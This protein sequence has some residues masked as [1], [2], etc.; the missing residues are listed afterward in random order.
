MVQV[1]IKFENGEHLEISGWLLSG[2]GL[3]M[4]SYS[5]CYV[6]N[7]P[8]FANNFVQNIQSSLLFNL[9]I[10]DVGSELEI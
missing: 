8:I 10:G 4:L 2:L 1:Q 3:L 9:A 5:L 7:F 6:Q